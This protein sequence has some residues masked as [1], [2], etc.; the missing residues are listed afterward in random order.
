MLVK[1]KGLILKT[2]NYSETSVIATIYTEQLGIK[3]YMLRGVR[4]GRGKRKG[5]IYQPM[6][7]LDLVVHQ[8]EN[9]NLQYISEA[10]IDIVFQSVPFDMR[11]TAIGLFLLEVIYAC[12]QEEEGNTGT[13]QFIR[14]QFLSLDKLQSQFSNFH[15]Q[16]LLQFSELLGF[17]PMN[18]YSETS[19]YFALRDG[20]FVSRFDSYPSLLSERQ[21][22]LFYKFL[23]EPSRLILK[24]D[25]KELLDV[26]ERYYQ[27]HI[28]NF[29]TFKT[30]LVF[31]ELFR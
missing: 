16:F 17:Q 19:N 25:R 12:I 21:S 7:F 23:E 13:Y 4:S 20:F 15:F 18:N 10:Q 5:N 22:V 2:I 28:V 30:P 9:K 6:Q 31:E 11:K 8:R 3:S 29:H 24:E 26:F 1:T 27:M 14:R